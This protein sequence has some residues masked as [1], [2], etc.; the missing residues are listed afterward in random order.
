MSTSS[1]QVTMQPALDD[2][3]L[4]DIANENGSIRWKIKCGEIEDDSDEE[5]LRGMSVEGCES[6]LKNIDLLLQH[7]KFLAK[8]V[9]KLNGDVT[10]L[11]QAL[12]VED[13]MVSSYVSLPTH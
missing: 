3:G 13:K 11:K 2:E 4:Q 1:I 9:K 8:K 5:G 6:L 7:C 10:T 12:Q